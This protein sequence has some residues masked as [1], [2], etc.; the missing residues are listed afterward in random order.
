[1]KEIPDGL[2]TGITDI[3]DHSAGIV[4]LIGV[5]ADLIRRS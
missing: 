3:G 1:M 2:E 4:E 5:V